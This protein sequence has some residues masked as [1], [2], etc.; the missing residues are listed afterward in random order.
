MASERQA[1]IGVALLFVKKGS[2]GSVLRLESSRRIGRLHREGKPEGGPGAGCALDAD[3]AAVAL[4]DRLA[5]VESQPQ[6]EI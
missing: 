5:D 3:L 6:A 2:Q 1:L 4:D